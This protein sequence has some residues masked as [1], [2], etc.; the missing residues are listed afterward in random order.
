MGSENGFYA[1]LRSERSHP[2][3]FFSINWFGHGVLE[4]QIQGL[5]RTFRY[6]FKDFQGP[7][8]FSRTFQA[9]KIWK[10]KFKDF[11][12]PVR[13]LIQKRTRMNLLFPAFFAE[14]MITR[15]HDWL[16]GDGKNANAALQFNTSRIK[17][18]IYEWMNHLQGGP[19][20]LAQFFLYA[21]TLANINRFSTL[22]HSQN[23]EKICN[24]T[25]AKDPATPQVCRYT[26]PCEM[27]VS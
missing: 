25:V 4:N 6:R 1:Y 11:Q 14:L 8:L 19:K 27:S 10:K 15:H 21:L 20:N 7:C 16:I 9:L 24:N 2:N 17:E 12:G 5:S 23:Q 22:F 3:T 26:I 13:A 18:L